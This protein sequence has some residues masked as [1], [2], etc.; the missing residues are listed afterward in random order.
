MPRRNPRTPAARPLPRRT[1]RTRWVPADD[2]DDGT[3]QRSSRFE[4]G[5]R[6]RCA[7]A[8]KPLQE[9]T[10][11]AKAL[12]AVAAAR[13]TRGDVV[14]ARVDF[15]DG[16]GWKTRP[17]V[18]MAVDRRDLLLRPITSS[19]RRFTHLG[20]EILDLAPAGLTKA[21]GVQARTVVVDRKVDV[22]A[23]LGQLSADDLAEV[24][25]LDAAM[26]DVA[27]TAQALAG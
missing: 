9:N 13:L 24:D 16:E 18:V 15:D 19:A 8:W 11:S 14:M 20:V 17:A 5:R 4:L 26:A 23:V 21:S 3:P 2:P 10:T 22:V 1:A 25:A 27:T 6:D 12:R 7:P